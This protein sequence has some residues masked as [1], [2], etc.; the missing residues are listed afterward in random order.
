MVGASQVGIITHG[1]P[2]LESSWEMMKIAWCFFG[3]A[4]IGA[5][6]V[7]GLARVLPQ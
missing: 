3:G 1:A 4:I 5:M 7:R 2:A 6:L